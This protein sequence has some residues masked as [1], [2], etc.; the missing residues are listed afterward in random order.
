MA[1]NP[2]TMEERLDSLEGRMQ[3][4]ED[5]MDALNGKIDVATD[6]IR[7]DIKLVLERVDSL[8]V[9]MRRGFQAVR[10]EHRADH[11]LIFSILKDHNTRLRVVERAAAGPRRSGKRDG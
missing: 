6:S 5:R 4:L 8:G 10:K 1:I 2:L 3:N 9:E 11:R 7:G